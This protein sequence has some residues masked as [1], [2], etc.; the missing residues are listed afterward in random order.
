[1]DDANDQR[2][3]GKTAIVTG[4]SRG[5]AQRLTAYGANIIII[6]GREQDDLGE[7]GEGTTR[8]PRTRHPAIKKAA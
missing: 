7:A 8:Q 1:M 6:T 5:I 3:S 4:G 2:L